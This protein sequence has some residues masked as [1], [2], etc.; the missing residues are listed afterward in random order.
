[1]RLILERTDEILTSNGGLA[2]AGAI[3]KSL[4]IGRTLNGIKKD[5]G[6]KDHHGIRY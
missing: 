1:M 3:M 6:Q 5:D 4:K 2:V